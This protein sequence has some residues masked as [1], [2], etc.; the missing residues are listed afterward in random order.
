M[1]GCIL[2]LLVPMM[3]GC[4]TGAGGERVERTSVELVER[5]E[6]GI[7]QLTASIEG[8]DQQMSEQ[9]RLPEGVDQD[10]RELQALDRAAWQLRRH[11]WVLQR[12]HL[13]LAKELLHRA[14]EHSLNKAQIVEKWTS[15]AREYQTK[16]E[17]LRQQRY[18]LERQ[19]FRTE[20]EVIEGVL[21]RS[22]RD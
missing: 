11:Q 6:E 8:L 16:L 13:A 1:R 2:G 12:D 20:T 7:A 9:D 18:E 17:E 5:L 10:F 19:R 3:M 4:A 14:K 22:G 21:R 15:H